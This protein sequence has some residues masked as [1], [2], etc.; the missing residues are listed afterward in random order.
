M[1]NSSS[2]KTFDRLVDNTSS[3]QLQTLYKKV[4]LHIYTVWN[5]EWVMN[6]HVAEIFKPFTKGVIF[7]LAFSSSH[8][9]HI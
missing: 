6:M 4:K 7:A 2:E 1:I 5:G 8:V 3:C 9:A